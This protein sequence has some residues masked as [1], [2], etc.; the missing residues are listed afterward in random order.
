MDSQA[1]KKY[2]EIRKRYLA[3]ALSFLGFRYFKFTNDGNII[4]NFKDTESFR[5]ALT[6]L[7]ILK[8]T[9]DRKDTD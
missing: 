3:E 6:Q 1:N 7:N 2:Y 5:S 9:Y 8:S 4:Y